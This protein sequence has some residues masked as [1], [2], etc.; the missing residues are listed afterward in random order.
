M[1]EE[2]RTPKKRR[3]T[4]RSS[5]TI[6]TMILENLYFKGP[7]SCRDLTQWIKK[8]PGCKDYKYKSIYSKLLVLESSHLLRRG[9]DGIWYLLEGVTPQTLI[10]GEKEMT[11][12]EKSEAE[13]VAE[14]L[15]GE[16]GEEEPGEEET[17]QAEK[18][19]RRRNTP[20]TSSERVPLDQV[21]MFIQHMTAIGVTPRDAIPTIADVF[22]EGDIDDLNWLNRVLLRT[23]AG[24]VKA[25][26]RRLMLDWWATTRQLP[27][28]EE[29]YFTGEE[30]EPKDAKSKKP[31]AKAD[32][33]PE[34]PLDAGMGWQ[35]GKDRQGD[36]VAL[37][38]GELTYDEALDRAERRAM[39][40]SYGRDRAEDEGEAA[41]D[42][43]E[44]A[45]VRKGKRQ[46]TSL[47]EKMMSKMVD[48][49]FDGA[50][51]Q[52]AAADARVEALQAQIEAM[53]E[54]KL[55]ERFE[56][57]EGLIAQAAARDPWDEYNHFQAQAQ[58]FGYGPNI[59]T[60]NSPAVQLIKDSS[61]KIDKNVAR[62]VGI[63]ERLILKSDEFS[64]EQTR[65][66]GQ[67]EQKAGELLETAQTRDKSKNLRR[68]TFGF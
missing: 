33:K 25:R 41:G 16:T 29:D 42:G 3:G 44:G 66:P 31:G 13:Q 14:E 28:K 38:G 19:T 49:M 15:R 61:D 8:E 67:R 4:A 32:K 60:D 17:T 54:D 9:Q 35:V 11:T 63:M 34:R 65:T 62:A 53:R 50:G 21:S 12:T 37:P 47:V 5:K 68:E 10:T 18:K 6:N 52:N 57:L 1:N 22:F 56:R 39:L 51:N 20:L 36:W 55:E 48:H 43:D 46:E 58:R 24:Y 59:V 64:P 45:P 30:E 40:A 23:A 2:K 27:Y 26:E 7:M